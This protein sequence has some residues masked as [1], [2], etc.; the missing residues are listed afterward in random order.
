MASPEV[1]KKKKSNATNGNAEYNKMD[2]SNT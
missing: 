2:N 1:K